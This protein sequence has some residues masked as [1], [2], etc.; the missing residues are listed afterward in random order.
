MP[1]LLRTFRI[2]RHAAAFRAHAFVILATLAC[3]LTV[4]VQIPTRATIQTQAQV[5]ARTPTEIVR[6]FYTKLRERR[7]QEAFAMSVYRPAVESLNAEELAELRPE[8]EAL[9]TSVPAQIEITGE[10]TSG[11]VSTVFM[12]LAGAK[13]EIQPVGLM[14]VKGAW[15]VGDMETSEAVR[16]AGKKFFIEARIATHHDEV[17]AI[18]TR[19]AQAQLAYSLQNGG[20]Y[21]DTPT[22]IKAGL[23][24]RDIESTDMIGYR[25][26][27]TP[28]A[29][30]KAFTAGAEPV[31]YNR[32]GR[33]SFFMDTTG[34][35]GKDTGGKP[36]TSLKK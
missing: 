17:T 24:P 6:E 19:I 32:T 22:L 4:G 18:M 11:D 13:V 30:R 14:R 16:K 33:L 36:L 29:D 8:F 23:L 28:S 20:A 25:F 2:F 5:T 12:K 34:M 21:A 35:I 7:F 1:R 3:L 31:R 10:Q 26:R 27:V 15:V 9:A